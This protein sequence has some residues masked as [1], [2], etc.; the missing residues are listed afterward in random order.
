MKRISRLLV[1]VFFVVFSVCGFA[2]NPCAAIEKDMIK[3]E[4]DA[5]RASARQDFL[6]IAELFENAVVKAPLCSDA[7]YNLGLAYEKIGDI[8]TSNFQNLDLYGDNTK[9][10]RQ[11]KSALE[12]YLSLNPNAQDETQVKKQIFKLEY[13]SESIDKEI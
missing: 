1:F 5:E 10:F 4:V 11:A 6:K 7:F 13:K 3:A 2:D 9:F 12:K 8:D